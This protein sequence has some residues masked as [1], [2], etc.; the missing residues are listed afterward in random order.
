MSLCALGITLLC[1][2]IEMPFY[3]NEYI[4]T[5]APPL[6]ETRV[7]CMSM[8]FF[9]GVG[10]IFFAFTNQVTLF[11]IYND[12]ENPS[13]VRILKIVKRSTIIVLLFYIIMGLF[14]YLSTLG[15]TPDIVLVR[16]NL[17]G[18]ATDWF[19]LFASLCVMIVMIV[20]CV[21]NYL[22]FRSSLYLMIKDHEDVPWNHNLIITGMFY[23][24]IFIVS[25]VFPKITEVLGIFG[26]LTSTGICYTIPLFCYIRLRN[27]G[28][29][30]TSVK[31]LC[32]IGYFSL[33]TLFGFLSIV[34]SLL[35]LI[36]P[37]SPSL[38]C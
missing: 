29:P 6:N 9:N 4:P 23:L 31:N 25:M 15:K 8:S 3:V 35:S 20:N 27:L 16:D 14:G 21:T 30:L 34:A 24:G 32:A 19:N 26:G 33:L 12:L 36:S 10:I 28:D 7:A 22:P 5:L 37:D 1:V 2:I 38:H 18:V 17:P 13:K 11:P